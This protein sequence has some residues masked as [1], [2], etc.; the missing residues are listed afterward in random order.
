VTSASSQFAVKDA[1]WLAESQ[2]HQ[3]PIQKWQTVFTSRQ[4]WEWVK[5]DEKEASRKF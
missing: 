3:L 1:P 4:Q 5:K 2:K